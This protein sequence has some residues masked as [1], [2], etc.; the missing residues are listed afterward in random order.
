MEVTVK[1]TVEIG[2]VEWDV[3]LKFMCTPGEDPSRT[4]PGC[5]PEAEYQSGFFCDTGDDAEN[6]INP[7]DFEEEALELAAEKEAEEADAKDMAA[8]AKWEERREA[9]KVGD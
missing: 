3:A 9:R 1:T 5:A 2:D 6:F 7:A 8:E 4:S